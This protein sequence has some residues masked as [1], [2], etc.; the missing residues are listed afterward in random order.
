MDSRLARSTPVMFLAA[1][2]LSSVAFYFGTDLFPSW[3]P[4]WV[5]ALPVLWAAPRMR[6]WIAALMALV[7]RA[8]GGSNMWSY[9][10][11]LQFPLFLNME[12]LLIPAVIF[13][14]A[15]LLFRAFVRQRRPWLALLAFPT[16]MVAA[17]YGLSLTFGTFGATAYT[18]LNNIAVLQIAATAGL[19]GVSFIILLFAPMVAVIATTP[20]AYSGS[21]RQVAIACVLV[22]GAVFGY[23]FWRMQST[24][25]APASVRVG[26]IASMTPQN[27]YNSGGQD[28]MRLLREYA[29]QVPILAAQGA[30]IV[31]LPEMTAVVDDTISPEVDAL[32]QQTAHAS[33][34]QIMVGVL[35]VGTPT[36]N[37]A[38]LYS[39]TTATTAIYH[40][41]HLVPVVEG[42]STPGDGISILSQQAGKIG[43]AVCRDMD[44][45]DPS[46]L[47]GRAG[48]GLLLVPAWDQTEDRWWHGHM[49]LMRGVENGYSI[50]RVAKAGYLT[51][52]DDRG[53]VLAEATNV[54]NETFTTLLATVPVRHDTTLYQS[55]GDWFAWLDLAGLMALLPLSNARASNK[56]IQLHPNAPPPPPAALGL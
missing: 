3:W 11:R 7:A 46:R 42:R 24:P 37:E 22:F 32:F 26:L 10:G 29:A 56:A 6:W 27:I 39:D 47:Y 35:H 40:K 54:P 34:V 49:A 44:Y 5:A 12:T 13:A 23:G 48:V 51:V 15:V 41:H 9:H 50:V 33:R 31:V 53:R 2:A 18:Q 16:C 45:P 14:L 28:A 52:S 38:R 17:E 36:F 43:L 19:W 8:I 4:I 1:T 30:S 21:A 25:A 20:V 55:W